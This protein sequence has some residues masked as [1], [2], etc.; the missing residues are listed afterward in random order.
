MAHIL[1]HLVSVQSHAVF[2]VSAKCWT[3]IRQ[4]TQA[5][6]PCLAIVSVRA[7][8]ACA[9]DFNDGSWSASPCVMQKKR[10]GDANRI[11]PV[12]S[13]RDSMRATGGMHAQSSSMD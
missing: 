8:T 7:A 13:S 9:A 11:S 3:T 1:E 10:P 2:E 6:R 12:D 5:P 4:R